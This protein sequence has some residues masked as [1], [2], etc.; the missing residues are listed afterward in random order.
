MTS[1]DI[2]PIVVG[3]DGS[4]SAQRALGWA[5]DEAMIRGCAVHVINAWD[6][7]PLAD[8]AQTAEQ[9]ARAKSESVV[10]DAVRA[11]AVGRHDFPEIVRR[12]LRG[13][14]AEV[15][16]NAAQDADL[17]VVASHTGRRLRDIVL[18]STSA[19]CVLHSATPVV[20]IP[21]QAAAER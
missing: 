20:V 14:A 5:M 17:L 15:L 18:G 12:S 3:I 13:T 1:A 2:K 9:A 4:P 16:E 19:H 11:D 6:Y 21:A 7:E 8:W 10:D